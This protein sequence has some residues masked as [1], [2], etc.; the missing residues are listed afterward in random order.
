MNREA[1]SPLRDRPHR[2]ESICECAKASKLKGN[3]R[4]TKNPVESEKTS[5][6]TASMAI[7][8]CGLM[9]LPP[10]LYPGGRPSITVEIGSGLTVVCTTPL[11]SVRIR[12]SSVG[13]GVA[14]GRA[15]TTN[16]CDTP[17][18]T[19]SIRGEYVDVARSVATTT[20]IGTE[21]LNMYEGVVGDGVGT[22]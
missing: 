1:S 7:I 18:A 15:V 9:V 19:C 16:F 8:L 12:V 2:Y 21:V 10:E 22:I 14:S 5:E 11:A 17:L 4:S 3:N 20:E 13:V 6:T